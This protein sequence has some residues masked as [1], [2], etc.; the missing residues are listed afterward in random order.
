MNHESITEIMSAQGGYG[1]GVWPNPFADKLETWR[2]RIRHAGERARITRKIMMLMEPRFITPPETSEFIE[3]LVVMTNSRHIIELGTCTG[4]C[5]LHMLRAIL[6]KDNSMIVT[7]DPRPAHDEEFF[8]SYPQITHL[9]LWTPDALA[10]PAV[11]RGAPYDLAFVDSDHTLEHTMKEIEALLP[12]MRNR[13]VIVFH[14]LPEWMTP[15]NKNPPPVR[16]WLEQ[17]PNLK[18]SVIPTCEQMDCLDAFGPGYPREVNP[19]LGVFVIYK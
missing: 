14:D 8:A 2:N 12:L 13:G 7:I 17:H 4:F 18:G 10:D 1:K 19:H 6:G 15:E 11:I 3:A 5:T 9:K 16:A